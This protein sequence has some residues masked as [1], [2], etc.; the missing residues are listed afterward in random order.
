[1]QA[2]NNIKVGIAVAVGIIF[3]TF[4]LFKAGILNG[5]FYGFS[6]I[7]STVEEVSDDILRNPKQ[8]GTTGRTGQNSIDAVSVSTFVDGGDDVQ[9]AVQFISQ[10]VVE[11]SLPV[12]ILEG[13]VQYIDLVPGSGASAVTGSQMTVGYVGLIINT[14]EGTVK[15]FDTGTALSAV[16]GSTNLI[17]GFSAGL[18]GMREGGKRLVHIASEAA[19]GE[20][21]VPGIPPNTALT[22]LIEAYQIGEL[23]Q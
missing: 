21:G 8:K 2:T 14:N 12:S 15:I 16:A 17:P 7:L 4:I 22:F 23:N 20:Q 1:M 3:F 5:L 6:P 18:I 10:L 19:Y 9:H 13:K 11:K